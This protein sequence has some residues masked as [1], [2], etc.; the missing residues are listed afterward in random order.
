MTACPPDDRLAALLAD[1]PGDDDTPALDAHLSDCPSCQARLD[2]L[3]EPRRL[4]EW[5]GPRAGRAALPFLDPPDRPGDLGRVGRYLVEAELG[6]GGMGLVLRAW[7][8]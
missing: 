3:S 6:R 7:D 1:A 4:A 5:I 8:A 2:T